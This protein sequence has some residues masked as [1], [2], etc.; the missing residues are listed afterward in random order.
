MTSKYP[1]K[2]EKIIGLFEMLPPAEVR[3]SL[4]SYAQRVKKFAPPEGV[5]MD[6]ES[7]RKDA[8]CEDTVGVFLKFDDAGRVA[9]YITT[10][11]HVQTLTNAL[12]CILCEGLSGEEPETVLELPADF[13]P[14]IV[15]GQLFRQR[16]QTV[17]YV[18][19]RMKEALKQ[20]RDIGRR[21]Q[22]AEARARDAAA[23]EANA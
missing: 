6:L 21:E 18:L 15:G 3:A 2:L 17:Y 20:W 5:E 9:F 8:E 14:R 16:S 22:I 19:R 23:E 13:V 7:I 1:P 4:I 10:G 12:A 11:E